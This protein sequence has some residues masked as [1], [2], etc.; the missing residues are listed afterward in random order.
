MLTPATPFLNPSLKSDVKGTHVVDVL[1][2]PPWT[3]PIRQQTGNMRR[4]PGQQHGQPMR[5]NYS[6][7]LAFI[8]GAWPALVSSPRRRSAWRRG[9]LIAQPETSSAAPWARMGTDG[10]WR[11]TKLHL[12]DILRQALARQQRRG[13]P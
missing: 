5:A 10:P 2:S 7:T 4:M 6:G 13:N 12:L 11:V 8:I 9:P 1:L 3:F